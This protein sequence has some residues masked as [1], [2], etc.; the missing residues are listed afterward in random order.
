M[1]NRYSTTELY[2]QLTLYFLS[3]SLTKLPRLALNYQDR[4]DYL[5]PL[6][7]LPQ[8]PLNARITRIYVSLG[9]ASVDFSENSVCSELS[10]SPILLELSKIS[11][12]VVVVGKCYN[13]PN[14]S[15]PPIIAKEQDFAFSPEMNKSP[16]YSKSLCI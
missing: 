10:T 5:K 14:F 16:C 12:L 1:R 13:F 7:F 4:P 9:P 2:F 6:L 8:S 3:Q 11:Y 15:N